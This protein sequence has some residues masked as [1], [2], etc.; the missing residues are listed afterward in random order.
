MLFSGLHIGLI[1]GFIFLFSS[2][3]WRQCIRCT[4]RI[5]AVAIGGY[6]GLMSALIYA[7]IAGFSIP[8]QRAFIMAS[9]VFLSIILR[10]Y[11]AIWQLYGMALLLALV[12]NPVSIFSVGFW[13]SFYVV[14]I[15]IY[16]TSQHKNRHW[17]VRLI[18][19]QLLISLATMPL[20]AWFFNSGS[21]F[22]HLLPI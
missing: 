14:A 13:L 21:I 7:L 10:R 12:I 20:V 9:V 19:I 8:T 2:F 4:L 3:L 11:H 17:I 16:G 18:Y 5:P 15:I 22:F 1:S 6:F